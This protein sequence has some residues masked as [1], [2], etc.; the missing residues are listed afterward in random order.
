MASNLVFHESFDSTRTA[1]SSI[2]SNLAQAQ[3]EALVSLLLGHSLTLSHTYAFDSR[4]VLELVRAVLSARDEVS[5]RLPRTSPA[6]ERLARARPVLLTW[7]GSNS[8]VEACAAQLR[9]CDPDDLPRRFKLSA[10]GAID[11]RCDLR[12]S[13]AD[14][15]LESPRPEAPNWL[16]GDKELVG[17]FETLQKI[18]EYSSK[19]DRGMA[20]NP[21]NGT[22][23]IAYL[24]CYQQLG[25]DRRLPG[26][27]E[28]DGCPADIAMALWKRI[29]HELRAENGRNRLSS[30]SWIH[31]AVDNTAPDHPDRILLEQLKE[32]VNTFYNARL[33]ESGY[34][35]HDFLS[36]VPRSSDIDQL[37][38][39]N[40]L[41]GGVIRHLRPEV[42]APPMAGVFTAPEDEPRLSIAPLRQIFRAYWEIISDDERHRTWS[43]SCSDVN[44]ELRSKPTGNSTE[45]HSWASR[46]SDFWADHMSLLSRQLPDVIRTDDGTLRVM[47]S[48]GDSAYQYTQ[49]ARPLADPEEQILTTDEVDSALATSRHISNMVRWVNR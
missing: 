3:A 34:A 45:F 33:A 10:W 48:L 2:Q 39:V 27:A 4:G 12:A 22:E 41:A 44:E 13:L 7:Y 40:A 11:L 23:L 5:M 46:F 49:H 15:L 47:G 38:Y 29:D 21:E 19:Y 28:R 35:E 20:A 43:K 1:D 37:K 14:A 30:R 26:L 24:D 18:I 16:A 32:L 36:S 9:K 17:H 6:R 42:K 25:E 31:V 8:F